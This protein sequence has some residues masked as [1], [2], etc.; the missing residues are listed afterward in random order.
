VLPAAIE[1]TTLVWSQDEGTFARGPH[2]SFARAVP[3][4]AP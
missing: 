4:K 1:V 3:A 2:Q